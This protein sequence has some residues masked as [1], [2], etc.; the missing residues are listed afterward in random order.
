MSEFHPLLQGA[1]E[2]HCHSAPSLF[3][4]SQTDWELVADVRRAGMAGVVLKSHEAQTADRASLLRLR[5]PG[6][7][8]YGGLVCNYFTGGL[9]P[10]AVDAAIRLG[11]KV[12]WMP[13][14]SA[15]QHR[16][17]FANKATRLFSGSRALVHPD[18]GLTVCDEQGRILPEV[19]HI[20]ELI[21]AADVVLATGHLSAAEVDRLVAAARE[22]QVR[23]ILIQ[24]ADVG[25]ARIPLEQ[26][27]ALARKGALIE[28]C[29]IA[30]SDDFRDL[31]VA[32]MAATIRDIGADCCVLATDYGQAH[33]EPPVRA[34]IRFIGELCGAGIDERD[35]VRMVSVNPR[36]LLGLPL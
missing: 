24:H 34:F 22:Q 28:K 14:L 15:A 26:Q 1:I 29:Y 17:Y 25:I 18:R 20:L 8:I 4:R 7:H 5:E 36:R 6:L 27:I 23:N 10:T 12:I 33:N 13:T 11:A 32:E 16:N 30:C 31:T 35:I 2:L 3:P 21:A 19:R 9:S